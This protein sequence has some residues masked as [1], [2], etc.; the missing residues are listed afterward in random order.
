[1][2]KEKDCLPTWCYDVAARFTAGFMWGN[3]EDGHRGYGSKYI[4]T[5]INIWV[6]V[7][8]KMKIIVAPLN[9]Q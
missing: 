4:F 1:M 3:K 8:I 6:S 2:D 9:S 7:Y 5:C